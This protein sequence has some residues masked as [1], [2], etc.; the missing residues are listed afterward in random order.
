MTGWLAWI[1]QGAV[2][3]YIALDAIGNRRRQSRG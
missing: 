3:V 1:W 2:T